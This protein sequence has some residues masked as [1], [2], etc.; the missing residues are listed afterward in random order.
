MRLVHTRNILQLGAA[1]SVL[2]IAAWVHAQNA[3]SCAI[4]GAI[5]D[6]IAALVPSAAVTAT[7][8]STGA[9]V[10]LTTNSTDSNTVELLA[11][12]D[13]P[14]AIKETAS[15]PRRSMTSTSILGSAAAF[16]A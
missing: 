1:L 12:G 3:T 4:T 16:A 6:S 14:V 7:N 8:Q 10:T 13:Y 15:R 5:T 11:P 2:C 9:A